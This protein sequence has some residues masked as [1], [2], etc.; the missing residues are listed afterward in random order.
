MIQTVN[1]C[2]A[3]VV[4]SVMR[5]RSVRVAIAASEVANK[6]SRVSLRTSRRIGRL[7]ALNERSRQTMAIPKQ[8]IHGHACQRSGEAIVA[9][10]SASSRSV[11]PRRTRRPAYDRNPVGRLSPSVHAEPSTKGTSGWASN[12][13]FT[14]D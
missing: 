8:A 9:T 14:S 5:T 4:S 13:P 10:S 12:N 1:V 3:T 6:M 2:E 11:T 7:D